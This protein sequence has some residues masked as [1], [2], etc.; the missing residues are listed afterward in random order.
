MIALSI[1][2]RNGAEI[3]EID[4][5]Q[6]RKT[7]SRCRF[8]GAKRTSF[9]AAS[10]SGNDPGYV[11]SRERQRICFSDTAA[12][13]FSMLLVVA[14]WASKGILFFAICSALRFYTAKDPK[15]T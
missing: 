1:A 13:Q 7:G 14:E 11:K 5:R 3:D 9:E 4:L 2:L 6:T 12:S 15:R 8:I 10:K